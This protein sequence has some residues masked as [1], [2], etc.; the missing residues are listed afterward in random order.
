MLRP[1]LQ[2]SPPFRAER[3]FCI[4]VGGYNPAVRLLH[5][6]CT[7]QGATKHKLV[8]SS[9]AARL[10]LASGFWAPGCAGRNLSARRSG[11]P[12]CAD[13]LVLVPKRKR[14]PIQTAA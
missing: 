9:G 4:V 6:G 13:G 2:P 5:G 11:C 3:A 14:P 1:V 12:P 7:T 10:F 8:I